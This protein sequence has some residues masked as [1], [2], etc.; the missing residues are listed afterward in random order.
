M[1]ITADRMRVKERWPDA[2]LEY[3]MLQ[4]GRG[5]YYTVYER[6]HYKS[7][8][9]DKNGMLAQPSGRM[10]LGIGATISEAWAR[11]RRSVEEL[12]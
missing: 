2:F 9:Y 5:S 11:A 12:C 6:Q 7:T 1:T 8:I 4:N 10:V 3:T